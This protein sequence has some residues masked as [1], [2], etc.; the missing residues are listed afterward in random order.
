MVQESNTEALHEYVTSVLQLTP[1]VDRLDLGRATTDLKT[2][3]QK[4]AHRIE[5][6]RTEWGENMNAE[7]EVAMRAVNPRFVL[8][9]WVLEEV[10]KAVERDSNSGKRILRKVLHVSVYI[11]G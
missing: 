6:E 10:I 1:E 11:A 3:L 9:Q 4:Y 7:R 5:S 8:R 2:W